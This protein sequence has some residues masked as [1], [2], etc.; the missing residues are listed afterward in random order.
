[1]PSTLGAF[2]LPVLGSLLRN[3]AGRR[4]G[5][6]RKGGR[7]EEGDRKK[8]EE[9][10]KEGRRKEGREERGEY[11][12]RSCIQTRDQGPFCVGKKKNYDD[13]RN[14]TRWASRHIPM[15]G[16]ILGKWGPSQLG[17]VETNGEGQGGEKDW[18]RPK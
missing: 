4:G 14:R 3:P 13:P 10:S 5:K 2:G 6:R 9:L 1:M 7:G 18:G 8:E 16:W 11:R 17:M 15:S 12:P